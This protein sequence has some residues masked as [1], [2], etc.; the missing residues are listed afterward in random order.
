MP[1]PAPITLARLALG[2]TGVVCEHRL[3]PADAALLRAMGLRPNARVRVC[4]RGEPCIVEIL[5]AAPGEGDGCDLPDCRC[6]IGLARPLAERVM[7]SAGP[8]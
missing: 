2:Q 6:R 3:D 7:V 5:P 8:A 4:R 1:D